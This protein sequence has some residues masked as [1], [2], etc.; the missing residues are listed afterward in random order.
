MFSVMSRVVKYINNLRVD[1]IFTTRDL[2]PLGPR[3]SIDVA[4][5][6]LVNEG[7]TIRLARGVFIKYRPGMRSISIH[8]VAAVKAAAF[9]RRIIRHS[10]DC[11]YDMGLLEKGNT[12]VTYETD[13]HSSRFRSRGRWIIFKGTSARKM[14]MADE[15]AGIA[16]RGLV[17][18]R[19]RFVQT[20]DVAEVKR[21]LNPIELY[22]IQQFAMYAPAWLTEM[23]FPYRDPPARMR[24]N[25]VVAIRDFR[26]MRC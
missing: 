11:A 23:F 15:V 12:S 24:N 7:F 19:E 4:T 1:E 2:L 26:A 25:N 3:G 8:E 17:H 21:Q 20:S 10:A 9:G 13:G 22:R 16:I 14:Q 5:S 18:L 6:T